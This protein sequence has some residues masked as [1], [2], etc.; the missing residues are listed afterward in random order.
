MDI[1][2]KTIKTKGYGLLL[3]ALQFVGTSK[4]NRIPNNRDVFK[5]KVN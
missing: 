5:L 1:E 4:C 3:D 2:K